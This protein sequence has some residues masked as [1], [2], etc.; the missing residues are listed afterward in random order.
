LAV[1]ICCGVGAEEVCDAPVREDNEE[2]EG[3]E[4]EEEAEVLES[5]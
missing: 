4:D 2:V 5:S 1:W 3:E